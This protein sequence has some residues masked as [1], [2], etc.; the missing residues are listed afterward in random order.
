MEEVKTQTDDS[1]KENA[2]DLF[3]HATDFL[4]TYYQVTV[5]NV[6]QKGINL[7]S[8]IINGVVLFFLGLF[9]LLFASLGLAWW[10]GDMINSR[11]GGF[12]IVSGVFV[13]TMVVIV[14]MR[15]KR[16]FP[17]LRNMITRKIYE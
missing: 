9:F 3:D 6:A 12:F 8:A 15:K 14:V 7:A 2:R 11:I 1:L 10:I 16:I 4:E 17:M 13:V 5:L